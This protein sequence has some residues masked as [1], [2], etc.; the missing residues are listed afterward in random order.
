[1][2]KKI[3][4]N[5]IE[6]KKNE[7]TEITMEEFLDVKISYI[8]IK[9]LLLCRLIEEAGI[10]DHLVSYIAELLANDDVSNVHEII[11]NSDL[12]KSNLEILELSKKLK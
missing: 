11:S 5:V 3:K 8:E 10:D 7:N 2:A 1:M 9:N 12:F 4:K 6:V